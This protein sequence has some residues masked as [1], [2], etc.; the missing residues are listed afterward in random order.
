MKYAAA[1]IAGA[2]ALDINLD[3]D[4]GGLASAVSGAA[5]EARVGAEWGGKKYRSG[6]IGTKEA[7]KYGRFSTRMKGWDKPGTVTSLFTYWKGDRWKKWN[8]AGWSEIDIELAPSAAT[9][10]RGSYSTNLIWKNHAMSGQQLPKHK[11]DPGSGW[12]TYSFEWTPD[13]VVWTFDGKEVRRATTHDPAVTFLRERD[14][15]LIMNFWVPTFHSWHKGF[16]P[17]DMPWYAQYDWVAYDEYDHNSKSF[18]HKWK[19]D[20]NSIDY[21]RWR[22]T[23]HGGFE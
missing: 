11:A 3:L 5:A 6:S 19:D 1:F 12:H 20:F 2:K 7:F 4:L 13:Y 10:D 21:G 22:V 16:N 9:K 18:R 15:H 8:Y 14:Q 23:D 17:S